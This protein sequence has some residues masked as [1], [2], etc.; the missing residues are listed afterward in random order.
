MYKIIFYC[1]DSHV[2][3][4]KEAMFDAGAGKIDNYTH[5]A[6]QVLG[7]GQFMP[8][9]GSNA[10]MGEVNQIEKV[11]EYQVEMICE[12]DYI[13]PVIAAL[14]QAHPYEVPAYQVIKIESL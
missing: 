4:V 13:H 1:P 6:W 2:N 8:L 10:F 12:P 5:C 14:K 7:E 9:M 3:Q 11:A